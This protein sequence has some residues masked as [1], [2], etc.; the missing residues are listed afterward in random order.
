QCQR[1][2]SR[3][4]CAPAA[5]ASLAPMLGE[6]RPAAS[7][8]PRLDA[9]IVGGEVS[10][11]PSQKI[12]AALTYQGVEPTARAIPGRALT[13]LRT[14]GVR[15]TPQ[16]AGRFQESPDTST[17]PRPWTVR[18]LANRP[19]VRLPQTDFIMCIS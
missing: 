11:W 12:I 13:A 10:W 8:R 16:I 9:E 5:T 14:S 4:Q 18:K 1:G 3:R 7:Q 17:L 6:P 19:S 2:Q 15:S